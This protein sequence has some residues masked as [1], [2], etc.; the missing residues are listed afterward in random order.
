MNTNDALPG[1]LHDMLYGGCGDGRVWDEPEFWP[2]VRWIFLIC[3][4]CASKILFTSVYIW[5]K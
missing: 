2:E 5:R 3:G 4:G 1:R